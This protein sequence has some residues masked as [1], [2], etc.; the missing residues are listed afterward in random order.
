MATARPTAVNEPAAVGAGV[1]SAPAAL[2][3]PP[4]S[5]NQGLPRSTGTG[6][7]DASRGTLRVRTEGVGGIVISG[8]QTAQL[9]TWDPVGFTTGVWL[10][11]TWSTSAFHLSA[12]RAVTWQGSK[13]QGSKWQG[14][15]WQGG[16]DTTTSYGRKWQGADWYGA[17]D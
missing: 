12:W 1:I 10:P 17:W 13:W 5:A 3:A 11:T 16:A 6:S 9:L 15:K 8:T 2:A 7:L 14:S 4:G